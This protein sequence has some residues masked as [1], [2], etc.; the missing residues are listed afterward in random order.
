MDSELKEQA[1]A[2]DSVHAIMYTPEL[3]DIIKALHS[4]Q[5]YE[6]VNDIKVNNLP[7]IGYIIKKNDMVLAAG[8]LRLMEGDYGLMDYYV[9]NG[10][11]S[12]DLRHQ[13]LNKLTEELI[14][15]AQVLKLNG[16]FAFIRDEGISKR[17]EVSGF[18]KVHES[19]YALPLKEF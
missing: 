14:K 3:V 19:V 4:S 9:S 5:T 8:F 1:P 16:I 15:T 11:L 18:R 10:Y 13:G 6:R 12:S 17:S 2:L 7:K